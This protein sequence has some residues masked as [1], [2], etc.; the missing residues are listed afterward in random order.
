MNGTIWLVSHWQIQPCFFIDNTF[1]V[2]EG[3]ESIFSM[4]RTHSAFAK[5][6]KAHFAGSQMNDSVIDAAAAK[7]ASGS[8]FLSYR[9]IGGK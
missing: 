5:T 4:I 7:V 6:S 8:H 2:A 3:I 9:L 1:V